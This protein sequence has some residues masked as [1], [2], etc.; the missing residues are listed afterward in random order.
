[1]WF[2]DS[3]FVEGVHYAVFESEEA[4]LAYGHVTARVFS[5]GAGSSSARDRFW[6][7]N[8]GAPVIAAIVMLFICVRARQPPCA[9]HLARRILSYGSGT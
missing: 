7:Y 4:A 5:T 1:M 8:I 9:P 2:I 3:T 6:L